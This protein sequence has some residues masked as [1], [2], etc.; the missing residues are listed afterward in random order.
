MLYLNDGK[1]YVLSSG[2]YREVEVTL[3]G[4]EYD[5]KAKNNGD[6]I[7]YAENDKKKQISV[8]E[9]YDITHRKNN[10]SEIL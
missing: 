1:I 3:K 4:K 2:Y 8:K 7:E 5:V 9:A 10:R 6:E